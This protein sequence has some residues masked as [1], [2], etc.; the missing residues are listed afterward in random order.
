MHSIHHHRCGVSRHAQPEYLHS[1]VTRIDTDVNL[2]TLLVLT[3]CSPCQTSLPNARDCL[4]SVYA[5]FAREHGMLGIR[6]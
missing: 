4:C 1:P 5:G 3:H 6:E 2:Q